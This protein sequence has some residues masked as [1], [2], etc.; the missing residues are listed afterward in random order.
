MGTGAKTLIILVLLIVSSI[1]AM[2]GSIEW[3]LNDVVFSDGNSA[4][5]YFITNSAVTDILS[6]DIVVSGPAGGAAFTATQMVSSYL[7]TE[8][9]A[10][11]S[12]FSKYMDLYLTSAM[13]G[14]GGNIT[15]NQGYDCPGCGVLLLA[16]S[17]HDPE[18]IGKPVSEPPILLVLGSSL[19]IL[20]TLLRRAI[21]RG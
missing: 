17:G 2:A 20:G 16:G 10:A 11:N 8:I 4:V 5:G 12:D 13:T 6:F 15:M 18:I 14:A 9:G 7:P 3:T 21:A 1:G 19:G